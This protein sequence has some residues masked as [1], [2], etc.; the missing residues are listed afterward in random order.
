MM[1]CGASSTAVVRDSHTLPKPHSEKLTLTNGD[2]HPLDFSLNG[3]HDSPPTSVSS[4]SM[5]IV[6]QM[7]Q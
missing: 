6:C 7:S 3:F 4:V 1:G 5:S 2:A